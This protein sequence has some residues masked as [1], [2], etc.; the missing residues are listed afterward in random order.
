[1]INVKDS[2]LS[3]WSHMSQNDFLKDPKWRP[4]GSKMEPTSSRWRPAESQMPPQEPQR[5]TTAVWVGQVLLPPGGETTKMELPHLK[6]LKG[7]VDIAVFIAAYIIV[8]IT[9]HINI[10]IDTHTHICVEK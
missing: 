2:W 6:L 8:Y 10:T 4:G 3:E 9:V 5:S 1:M 7:S